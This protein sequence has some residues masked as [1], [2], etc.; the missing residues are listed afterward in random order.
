[1]AQLPIDLSTLASLCGGALHA[2]GQGAALPIAMLVAGAVSGGTHCALM[3][4]P[5]VLA[6]VAAL[7]PPACAWARL[8]AGARLPYQAGRIATYSALG[9][10]A[11]MT[12]RELIRGLREAALPLAIIIAL[13]ALAVALAAW[14]GTTSALG[15]HFSAWIAHH[16]VPLLQARG[17]LRGVRLGLL[18]GLLP[19]G[20]IYAALSVAA[21]TGDPLRGAALMLAFG[22]G[23]LPGLM[24][25]GTVGRAFW[26]LTG[27]NALAMP[28]A[29]NAVLFG[30]SAWRVWMAA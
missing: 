26:R 20:A 8:T 1:M 30:L 29:V 7:P 2:A 18:M 28:M 19:C 6:Q 5:L 24:A 23:T 21:S 16:A 14:R 12:G 17:T 25:V 11:G 4:G 13:L 22:T 15:R 3:C 9:A 10:L 27:R